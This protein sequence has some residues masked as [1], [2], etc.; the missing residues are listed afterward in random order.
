MNE[1]APGPSITA[2]AHLAESSD[3]PRATVSRQP[4]CDPQRHLY[5]YRLQ[6][7]S[8]T[9]LQQLLDEDSSHND[10]PE[11]ICNLFMDTG[12]NAIVGNYPA[13]L[14]L[15]R[16]LMLMDYALI[17]PANRVILEVADFT[18]P[19][20]EL[21]E[22]VEELTAQGYRFALNTCLET[23]TTNSLLAA[24]DILKVDLQACTRANLPEQT[25][26]WRQYKAALLAENVNTPD[27]FAYC[28]ELGF[29]YFQGAFLGQTETLTLRRSPTNRTTLLNLMTQL[30]DP[31][32][33]SGVLAKLIARD[34]AFGY[35]LLRLLQTTCPGT[36]DPITSI[37]QAVQALGIK[38][39][40]A[41]SSLIL[42]AGLDD[43]PPELMTSG[44]V[45]ARMCQLVAK[46]MELEG[47]DTFFFAGWLY[48]LNELMETSMSELLSELPIGADVQQALLQHEGEIGR[49][50]HSVLAYESGDWDNIHQLGID[51][52]VITDSYL[53]ALVWA[54]AS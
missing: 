36:P 27:D 38:P 53:R 6:G 11:L 2:T 33:Q 26:R 35:K 14:R 15:T 20:A 23:E 41:W 3:K 47:T 4:I 21:A 39:L 31:R 51:S 13:V 29:D 40:L 19:D 46:G 43:T 50:L 25:A 45:R 17:L 12:L 30:I 7:S 16:G 18:S 48:S 24:A 42:I 10:T 32:T 52:S 22:A 44:L 8:Q 28:Q 54:E 1:R 9:R 34:L 5:A 49:I 37:A